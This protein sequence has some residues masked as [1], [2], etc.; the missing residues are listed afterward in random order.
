M[1]SK[2]GLLNVAEG[3]ETLE[4]LSFFE[5]THC[6]LLQGYMFSK[7]LSTEEV[8]KA[9]SGDTPAFHQELQNL[10]AVRPEV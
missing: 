6:D 9:F 7:P 2:L 5:G 1:S 4:Q 3:I 10:R 8:E